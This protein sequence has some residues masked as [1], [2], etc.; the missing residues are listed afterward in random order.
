MPRETCTAPDTLPLASIS[1]ASRTSTTRACPLAIISLASPGD[2]F[3]TAA[4]AASSICLTLVG[5]AGLGD[6]VGA[7]RFE[8]AT[9]CTPCRYATRLRYAPK[10]EILPSQGLE[11]GAQLALD[12]GDVHAVARGRGFCRGRLVVLAVLDP[13]VLADAHAVEPVAGAADREAFFVE[14]LADA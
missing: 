13:A 2:S 8:L 4:F 7:A 14:K 3:G 10:G 12:G 9:T 1:G 5:M 6:M 11:N